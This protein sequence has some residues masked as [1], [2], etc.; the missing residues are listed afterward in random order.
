MWKTWGVIVYT[1]FT[2]VED[3]LLPQLEIRRKE[4]GSSTYRLTHRIQRDYY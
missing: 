2:Q 4:E 1:G 3:C